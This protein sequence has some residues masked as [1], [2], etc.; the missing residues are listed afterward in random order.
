MA[1]LCKSKKVVNSKVNPKRWYY[2]LE[3]CRL[4]EYSALPAGE[5]VLPLNLVGED[6]VEVLGYVHMTNGGTDPAP[7]GLA[8]IATVDVAAA[9]DVAALNTALVAALE[10]SASADLMQVA[11]EGNGVDIINNFIGLITE[12]DDTAVAELTITVGQQSFGGAIGL[13]SEDGASSSFEFEFLEQFADATGSVAVEKWLTG[14]T[15]TITMSITDTSRE[16]FEELF[17]K[18]LGGTYENGT[19]KLIGFGT[20]SFFQSL[21][22]KIGKLIGVDANATD[23]LNDW[24]MLAVPNPSSINFNKELQ[25]IECEFVSALDSTMPEAINI[26]SIGDK[27]KIDLAAL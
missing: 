8:L 3:H 16:K 27:T 17:V 22:T 2:G 13:L 6:Y 23:R 25:V 7:A 9:A 5:T 1:K 21:M 15:A 24:Q 11:E 19:D 10:G 12:E 4:V 26:F 18:P 20:A 14:L